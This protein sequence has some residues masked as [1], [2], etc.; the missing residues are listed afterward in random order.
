ML[1]PNR[2]SC[3]VVL[4]ALM[5]LA[6]GAS[7]Q[8][9]VCK[10]VAGHESIRAEEAYASGDYTQAETLYTQAL[11][12]KPD[13]ERSGAGLVRALLRERK[14]AEAANRAD[15]LLAA[16]PGSAVL[17][18]ALAEAQLRQGVPWLAAKT[19]ERS[20]AIDPCLALTHLI[21]SR[22][23]RVDSM[24]SSERSEIQAAYAIDPTDAEIAR[25]WRQSV[26][27]ANDAV[28]IDK[29]MVGSDLDAA[30][31]RKAQVTL[32]SM[33]SGLSENSQTCQVVSATQ[34]AVLPLLPS[35]QDGKHIDAYK[36]EV[37][38]PQTKAV[39]QVDTAASGLYISRALADLN[40][41]HQAQDGMPGTVY[42]ANVTIGPLEFHE[43]T[44]GVSD[45]PFYEKADGYIG[46]DV[47][48]SY[49]IKLDQ[50]NQ[51][52]ELSPLPPLAGTV[53]PSDRP[54]AAELRGFTPVYHRRQYLLVPVTLNGKERKLFVLDSGLRYTTMP[55]K[56]A[57]AVSTTQVNFTNA[58]QT[59]SGATINVYRDSFD[60]EFADL[61]LRNRSHLLE[62]E[63]PS[64]EASVGM[65]LG[66]LLGFDM[67]HSM[68]M[69]LDYRDGLIK[70]EAADSAIEVANGDAKK[71]GLRARSVAEPECPPDDMTDQPFSTLIT[72]KPSGLWDSANLK[73]GE[74]LNAK[75]VKEWKEWATPGCRLE[76]GANLY[77]HVVSVARS[78]HRGRAELALVFD[79]GDCTGHSR[80]ALTL[81]VIGLLAPDDNPQALHDALPIEVRGAG[82]RITDAV[83]A[84][85][86]GTDF[87]L[88]P[89]KL[90]K[91]VHPGMVTRMPGVELGLHAGPHC[92]VLLRSGEQNVRV[93][94]KTELLLTM[95]AS[96]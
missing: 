94:P 85:S 74:A 90:P 33:L 70:L 22:I 39:L 88:N 29:S 86:F 58:K 31:K 27:I 15:S 72:A 23:G 73:V 17:L 49:L 46:T 83:D 36:L 37:K 55:S 57:H 43:C 52:L 50:P 40:D 21:R 80:Q 44:L 48:S 62:M 67:L 4:G 81:N 38:L 82:R 60:F 76:M 42:A 12:E 16:H 84:L 71:G 30:A 25:A 34:S 93:G 96:H 75:V 28:N 3:H 2:T 24:Y 87:N 7:A 35:I 53:L 13:D 32:K 41:L 9:P 47:F 54:E 69:Q 77:G 68:V 78:K 45:T 59:T 63:S 79:Q 14:I 19:L 11:E 1:I 64:T 18:T 5:A 8:S 10:V 51:K 56:V 95:G 89:E 6:A 20:A 91:M 26:S 92:S 66:G 65:Q 61:L